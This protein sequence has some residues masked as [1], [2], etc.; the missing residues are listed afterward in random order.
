MWY[1]LL[2][3]IFNRRFQEIK[4]DPIISSITV[5]GF[6]LESRFDESKSEK[7]LHEICFA[8]FTC[9][10]LK[11]HEGHA[12]AFSHRPGPY[13]LGL[14]ETSRKI[15]GPSSLFPYFFRDVFI[16]SCILQPIVRD[17]PWHH[18]DQL[19]IRALTSA[20]EFAAAILKS[21]FQFSYGKFVLIRVWDVVTIQAI[22]NKLI[23]LKSY[24]RLM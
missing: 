20:R 6:F 14:R 3:N 24:L 19:C 8:N 16:S 22:R 12:G 21:V 4:L 11:R 15:T 1:R 9:P 5:V 17:D 2:I 10:N 18:I 23:L 13:V 7:G